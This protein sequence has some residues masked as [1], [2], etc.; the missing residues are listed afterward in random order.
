MTT[1]VTTVTAAHCP[2][3]KPLDLDITIVSA[4]H[5]KNVNWRNGDL[6]P[7][8]I[9]WLHPDNRLATK[10]DDS[11]ST[12]PVW[13]E[14]FVIPLPSTPCT[15]I[16]TLE[17]FHA[18]PSDTPK[19]L[20]GTLRVSLADLPE[21][22]SLNRI[23][24]FDL[25]RPSGRLNGKIRLK[26]ALRERPLPDYHN[27]PHSQIYY[28]NT[29]PP[30][31]IPYQYISDP[32]LVNYQGGPQPPPPSSQR[33]SMGRPMSYGGGGGPMA[34]YAEH[35]KKPRMGKMRSES[36]LGMPRGLSGL[37]IDEGLRYEDERFESNACV[38]KPDNYTYYRR[39]DY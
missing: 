6:N 36:G 16:L 24:T 9:F 38:T 29:P 30:S 26:L 3:A 23:R 5:L 28:N 20:I 18:K 39:V 35:D 25:R 17:M 10:S 2:L 31:Y 15:T 1:S 13:N 33:L 37:R 8:A 19:P 34:D 27:I 4:K 7:Y 14:R 32:H 21:P 11:N 12:K 22:E